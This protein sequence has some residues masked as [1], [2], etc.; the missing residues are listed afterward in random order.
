MITAQ[1][2]KDKIVLIRADLDVPLEGERIVNEY[3][4]ECLLPTL[5]LCLQNANKVFIIGHLGRPCPAEASGEGGPEGPDPKFSLLPIK[6]WLE[7]ALQQP[8]SFVSSGFSPGEWMGEK[9]K[10]VMFENIRFDKR[11]L[12]DDF[13]FARIL[14]TGVDL[15][16]YEAFASYNHATTLHKIPEILPTYPGLQFEREVEALDKIIK[17]SQ[18][19]KTLILSGVKDDKKKFFDQLI[20]KFD[21][22]LIGGKLATLI[23]Y[24]YSATL[25]DDGFDIDL[26]SIQKFIKIIKR[27]QTVVINGPL[28]KFEDGS[29]Y[30]ATK[31]ILAAIKENKTAFSVIGGGDTL[32]AIKMLGFN[33]SDFS[34]VSTGGGAMLEYLSTLTHPL[35]NIIKS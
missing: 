6:K 1:L 22:L 21:N 25:T 5:E 27:S 15:Y 32:S 13:E 35:L 28:G 29:H 17:T 18:S 24:R 10:I 4:L 19:P 11:E 23:P 34:F 9:N 7:T 8:I 16:I 33:Y 12:E 26:K 14:S 3:R 20:D 2:L 31:A 30:I